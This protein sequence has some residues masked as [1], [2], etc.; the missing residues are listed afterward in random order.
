MIGLGPVRC[1]PH[2]AGPL[3][4]RLT[5]RPAASGCQPLAR[6]T[7]APPLD[8]SPRASCPGGRA[9]GL[10]G[11]RPRR[12]QG[13]RPST[14]TPRRRRGSGRRSRGPGPAAWDRGHRRRRA[15]A[16]PP[17]AAGRRHS[18][19]MRARA[20]RGWPRRDAADRDP[21]FVGAPSAAT[22]ATRAPATSIPAAGPAA[23][24]GRLSTTRPRPPHLQVSGS[25]RSITRRRTAAAVAR[26]GH[27]CRLGT[28]GAC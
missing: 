4:V 22:A 9:G 23:R 19:A 20:A 1:L 8:P 26:P 3:R 13:P 15:G 10:A 17:R 11:G 28:G 6:S 18:S 27:V 16:P 12:T 21:A 5:L 14:R 24:Q 25:G 2:L 7:G